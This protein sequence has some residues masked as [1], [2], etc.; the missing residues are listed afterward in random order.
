MVDGRTATIPAK[1]ISEMPLPTPRAVTCS[2]S[3]IRNIVPPVRVTTVE[4]MKKI[5][6]LS[7]RPAVLFR[8]AAMPKD[9]ASARNT[10][11]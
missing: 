2:P 8:P 4:M 1:M 3:H 10:V 9:C 6:G 11:R 7:T 5:P